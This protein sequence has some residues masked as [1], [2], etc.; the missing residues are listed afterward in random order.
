MPSIESAL[1]GRIAAVLV[2]PGDQISAGDAVVTV[3]SM[4]MEIPVETEVDG[5]VK[6]VL[7]AVGDEVG[8]GQVVVELE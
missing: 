7:L 4:K 6:A 1:A 3:E 2:A 5:V 8:E